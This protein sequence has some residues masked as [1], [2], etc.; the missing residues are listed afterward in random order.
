MLAF[1]L[2]AGYS[3]HQAQANAGLSDFGKRNVE[4]LSSGYVFGE[5]SSCFEDI[6]VAPN[7]GSLAVWV[8]WC[9]K[10]VGMWAVSANIPYECTA[11]GNI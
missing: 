6:D 11:N 2:L 1:A 10:C 9:R 7:D 8:I 4:A 5:K 3:V